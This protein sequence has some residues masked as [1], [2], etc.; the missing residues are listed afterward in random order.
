MI[1]KVFLEG[2]THYGVLSCNLMTISLIYEEIGKKSL[3]SVK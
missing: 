1:K 2:N 3:R